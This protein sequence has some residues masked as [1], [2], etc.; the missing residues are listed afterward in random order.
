MV[1][2]FLSFPAS[3]S[4]REVLEDLTS[5]D[6]DLSPNLVRFGGCPGG[7]RAGGQYAGRGVHWRD[8]AA[9]AEALWGRPR[10]RLRTRVDDGY[11]PVRSFP[12]CM[13][14]RLRRRRKYRHFLTRQRS[15]KLPRLRAPGHRH[16]GDHMACM[17]VRL[18]RRGKCRHFL[19][20]QRSGTL[21]RLRALT[22]MRIAGVRLRKC[23]TP[24][25]M[26]PE[27]PDRR[28]RCP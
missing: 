1:R 13:E 25:I 20:R 24:P 3:A 10:R 4:A 19:T 18:R 6:H 16:S 15:G 14:V 5:G 22:G 2:D 11:R 23:N 17:E 8:G 27:V 28:A 12:S 21:P 7:V 9:D 26:I